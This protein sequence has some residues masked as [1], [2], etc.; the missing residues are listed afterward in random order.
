MIKYLKQL[1]LRF[2][3]WLLQRKLQQQ[4]TLLGKAEMIGTFVL[5]QIDF[6]ISPLVF[7]SLYI[8]SNCDCLHN[9]LEEFDR[10]T[11]EYI[12]HKVINPPKSKAKLKSRRLDRWCYLNEESKYRDSSLRSIY[13]I[14]LLSITELKKYRH[15]DHHDYVDLKANH[16]LKAFI[17]FS[18][19][20][21][22]YHGQR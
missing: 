4:D 14:S 9:M 20:L 2:K 7:H 22:E 10:I 1:N 15:L 21:V 13:R 11:Y 17:S 18:E 5:K 8:K 16:V 6:N 12:Y 3:W 19:L